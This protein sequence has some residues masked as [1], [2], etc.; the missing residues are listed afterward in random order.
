MRVRVQVTEKDIKF[1]RRCD[2]GGCPVALALRR[3]VRPSAE[4]QVDAEE[5]IVL[6]HGDRVGR[7]SVPP[8]V[9]AFIRAVDWGG[10]PELVHPFSFTLALPQVAV[11]PS[12]VAKAAASAAV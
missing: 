11:R 12:L 7:A 1:G 3:V 5:V 9:A 6:M 2:L 8:G 10:C 4:V